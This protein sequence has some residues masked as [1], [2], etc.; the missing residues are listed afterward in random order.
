MKITHMQFL[1]LSSLSMV[2]TCGLV[3]CSQQMEAENYTDVQFDS[4][5]LYSRLMIESRIND[6]YA[7]KN[8]MGFNVYDE[9][10]NLVKKNAG[11]SKLKFDYVPGLVAKALIEGAAYYKDSTFARPWFYT[12][13]NYANTYVGSVPTTGESLDNLNAA[14]MYAYLYD[15]TDEGGAY[16]AI[17]D[18]S[19]HSNALKAMQKAHKGLTDANNRY[20]IKASVKEDAAG[21]WFHKSGYPNQMWCDGQYMGP[22]LLGL[23]QKYDLH[24]GDN[25]WATITRQFDITWHYLWDADKELLWHAFSAD[26]TS[27]E[28]AC[29]ADPTT[30]RSA[31]Y[32]GRACGWYFLALVD[33]IEMMPTDQVYV[34]TQSSLSEYSIDCRTRLKQYLEQLAAGLKK[35]QD[36]ETGCWYQLLAYD[37]T[38]VADTYKGKSYSPKRN[39]LESSASAIFTATYLKAIRLGYL[40]AD[41][42]LPMAKKAYEGFVNQFVKQKEDG[43]LALVN[44]CASAGL[45]GGDKRDGSAAYYLLGSDVTRITNYTE[46]KVLGAFLLA[47]IEY[48]RMMNETQSDET[49]G[50]EEQTLEDAKSGNSVITSL[51]GRKPSPNELLLILNREIVVRR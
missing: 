10:G 17:A 33:L 13:E 32:W 46:G 35:R 30:G 11:G 48:E 22:A 45:G 42:Y 5:Q 6:F 29:W 31:E 14:K 15:L 39:Y 16:A 37:S 20:V 3:S 9:Q 21:G 2:L 44:S 27:S 40:P 1:S 8:Q 41:E 24:I 51:S 26:P 25:D 23:L 50:I 38:F 34:P 18:A 12:V 19:T 49:N 4:T 43:T 7:N 28:S 36:P 47:A